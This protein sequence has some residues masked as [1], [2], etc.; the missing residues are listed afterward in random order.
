[1]IC[2]KEETV[3]KTL[4]ELNNGYYDKILYSDEKEI[5]KNGT[6]I[7]TGISAGRANGI[8]AASSVY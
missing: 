1:M 2:A 7:K 6:K 4:T 5:S 8:K 3:K